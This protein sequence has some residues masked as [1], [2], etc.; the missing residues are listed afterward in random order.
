MRLL[1]AKSK[2]EAPGMALDEFMAQAVAA[3]F[4]A[5]ELN[6]SERPEAAAEIARLA[7]AHGLVVLAQVIC[8]GVS[9]E[10]QAATFPHLF[11]KASECHAAAVNCHIGRDY[12]SFNE[13]DQLYRLAE[14]HARAAGIPCLHETHRARPTYSA[15]ST[16]EFLEALPWLRLTADFS[17]WVCVHESLLEGFEPEVE[18]A[19]GRSDWIHARIG[20]PQGPQVGDP[21]S[22]ANRIYLEQFTTWWKRIVECRRSAGSEVVIITP[23]A[24]PPPYMPV[25][26]SGRV[27]VA[28]AW[29][30]NLAMLRH[31]KGALL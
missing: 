27:P 17:H 21:F 29:A 31:L 4:G 14:D 19:I 16:L 24:G 2:W 23:E 22:P 12:F 18:S 5:V 30:V 20:F 8:S 28:D 6:I 9:P 7:A 11:D 25:D 26:A 13:N 15:P 3:G 1:F 10:E